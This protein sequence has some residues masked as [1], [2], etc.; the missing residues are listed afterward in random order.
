M[1]WVLFFLIFI[2]LSVTS[3]AWINTNVSYWDD[4]YSNQSRSNQS[5][6]GEVN[7]VNTASVDGKQVPLNE[8]REVR[9][10]KSVKV[11]P[12]VKEAKVSKAT[13]SL[14]SRIF[15]NTYFILL[16][17]IFAFLVGYIVGFKGY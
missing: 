11:V 13:M 15:W 14:S 6:D 7:P 9:E 16:A 2:L 17:I 8:V 5:D 1:K 10:I 4:L 3:F 12:K